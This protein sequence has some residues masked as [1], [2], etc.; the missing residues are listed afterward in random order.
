MIP[1][2]SDKYLQLSRVTEMHRD[3]QRALITPST[4]N[5]PS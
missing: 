4:L 1:G 5:S 3:D 2:A